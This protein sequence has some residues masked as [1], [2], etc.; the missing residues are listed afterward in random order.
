MII[1]IQYQHSNNTP[2]VVDLSIDLS[3]NRILKKGT[4]RSNRCGTL[5]FR[6]Q[7][8]H[9]LVANPSVWICDP[10][11]GKYIM[12]EAYGFVSKWGSPMS[13]GLLCSLL[14]D[15]HLGVVGISVSKDIPFMFA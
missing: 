13:T 1:W 14:L 6:N 10:N 12:H 11:V 9:T 15:C 8:G 2:C 7:D 5:Q 3:K 4:A